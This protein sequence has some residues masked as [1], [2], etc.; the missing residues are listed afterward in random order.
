MAFQADVNHL[1][2]S[3]YTEMHRIFDNV[4]VN[5]IEKK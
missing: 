1:T 2:T 5:Q 4:I 3:I